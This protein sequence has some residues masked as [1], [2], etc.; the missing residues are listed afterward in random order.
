[1]S[2]LVGARPHVVVEAGAGMNRVLAVEADQ[3]A[4]PFTANGL[5]GFTSAAASAT[6]T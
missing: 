4:T 5:G 1:M 3:A 2:L 6:F